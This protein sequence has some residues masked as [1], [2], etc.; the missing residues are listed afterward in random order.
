MY[1]NDLD[2][3]KRCNTDVGAA[4]SAQQEDIE[5][6]DEMPAMEDLGIESE[7]SEVEESP[8]ENQEKEEKK[9]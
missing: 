6:E 1:T 2:L 4:I 9:E 8:A 5:E 3:C 7:A